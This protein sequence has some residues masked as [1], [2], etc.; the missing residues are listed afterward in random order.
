[1]KIAIFGGSFNPITKGHTRLANH[2]VSNNVVDKVLIMPCYKSLYNKGLESGED[3]LKMI[4]LANRVNGVEPFDWEIANKIEDQ[5]T[6]DIMKQLE[7]FFPNDELY[8]VIGLDNSQKIK[9]WIKGDRITKEFKFVIVPRVGTNTTDIWFMEPPHI[10]LSGYEAD[11]ISSTSVK[12][13]LAQEA[14]P[15]EMLDEAVYDYIIQKSL[16]KGATP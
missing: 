3:R 13:I 8:F 7:A 14:N 2:I 16:Y 12:Q 5:G 1:M 11:D 6:Y 4:E 10:F 15:K 9:S